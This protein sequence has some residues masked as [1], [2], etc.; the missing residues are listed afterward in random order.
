ME[1]VK[2]VC[3]RTL[4]GLNIKE[5]L[6]H[7]SDGIANLIR[8]YSNYPKNKLLLELTKENEYIYRIGSISKKEPYELDDNVI[9]TIER[10]SN[11]YD[12]EGFWNNL[13]TDKGRKRAPADVHDL[14]E[15][16]YG[17]EDEKTEWW[18]AHF[19]IGLSELLFSNEYDQE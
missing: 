16:E 17:I 2:F 12:E 13:L 19:F 8:E 9:R 4:N 3:R 6:F 14:I 15:K 10:I 18:V 1:N 11:K 5:Y 7:I